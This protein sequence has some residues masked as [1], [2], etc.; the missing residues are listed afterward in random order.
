M[1]PL[2]QRLVQEKP[3]QAHARHI[4]EHINPGEIL[5]RR[6]N[7][8][9]HLRL[10]AHIN[11]MAASIAA[12]R[13]DLCRS[14]GSTRPLQIGNNDPSSLLRK[15]ERDGPADSTGRAGNDCDLIL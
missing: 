14:S 2:L 11:G 6:G 1:L 4:H 3:G 15:A 13:L 8:L 10:V 12:R 9:F 5:N 7:Q